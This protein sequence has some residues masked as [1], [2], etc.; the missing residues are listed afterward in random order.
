MCGEN[1]SSVMESWCQSTSVSW[2][3]GLS[4]GKGRAVGSGLL[5]HLDWK[6]AGRDSVSMT[7]CGDDDGDMVGQVRESRIEQ[8]DRKKAW[9][10]GEVDKNAADKELK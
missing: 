9:W 8:L 10:T 1:W 5:T 4:R 2:K 6:F 7:G 3:G